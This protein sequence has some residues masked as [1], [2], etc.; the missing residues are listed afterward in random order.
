MISFTP[1]ELAGHADLFHMFMF[2]LADLT[3]FTVYIVLSDQIYT[4]VRRTTYM[5][6]CNFNGYFLINT[7]Y[8]SKYRRMF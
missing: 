5:Y 4:I 8:R 2:D 7:R 3:S 1:I 6:I